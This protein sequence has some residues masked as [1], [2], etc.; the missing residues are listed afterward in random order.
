LQQLV[1]D[2]RNNLSVVSLT[3]T[4]TVGLHQSFCHEDLKLNMAFWLVTHLKQ[5]IRMSTSCAIQQLLHCS[6]VC[7]S[8]MP[9]FTKC[10]RHK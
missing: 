9:Q 5:D 1:K 8:A 10:T 6:Y 3:T 7:P 4:N 2:G